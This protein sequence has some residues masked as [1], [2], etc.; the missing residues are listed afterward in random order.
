MKQYR[1]Y[2]KGT[3]IILS[4][5]GSVI[6]QDKY[7]KFHEYIEKSFKNIPVFTA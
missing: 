2:N 4:C 3:A 7:F 5:F 6:E 1:H